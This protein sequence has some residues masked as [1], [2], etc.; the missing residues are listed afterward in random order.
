MKGE[1][2]VVSDAVFVQADVVDG[3]SFSILQEAPRPSKIHPFSTQ[4][5]YFE[6]Q[7]TIL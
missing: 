1:K 2:K 3:L 6:K 7:C 5:M 4:C